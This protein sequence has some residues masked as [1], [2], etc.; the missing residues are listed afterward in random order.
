M[1]K[2]TICLDENYSTTRLVTQEKPEIINKPED[3]FE[4]VLFLPEGENRK[5][6]GG[7]RSQGYFKKSFDNKPLVSIITV[8]YNGEKYLEE[9]IQSV[10]NQTY[11]NVEYIIIDGGSKDGTVDIIKKYED[12]ID[13]WVSEQDKG[14]YDAMNKGIKLAMGIYIGILNADDFYVKDAIICSVEKIIK[15]NVDYSIG[16]VK[17]VNGGIIKP[18]I[19]LENKIYQEMPYPHVSATISKKIYKKVGLFDISFKIA[20]DHDMAIKILKYSFK[21]I[22]LDKVLAYLH[23]GGVSASL[24]SNKE[25]LNVAIKNGKNKYISYYECIK[26]IIKFFLVKYIF[27]EKFIKFIQKMKKSRFYD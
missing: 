18:I 8:V 4:S 9:T 1:I 26:S 2:N 7:L 24:Q 22:Y 27:P 5:G 12:K 11:D 19:P 16:N 3:K 14:I 17:F 20:G 15:N 10:I 6:E 13:Y 25:S 21:Y 23:E